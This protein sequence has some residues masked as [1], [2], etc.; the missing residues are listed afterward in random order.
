MGSWKVRGITFRS[1]R[2]KDVFARLQVAKPQPS[3]EKVRMRVLIAMV[4][5]AAVI[6]A[7]G[8]G[9][10]DRDV[11][12]PPEESGSLLMQ[13]A[14]LAALRAMKVQEIASGTTV[15]VAHHSVSGDPGGGMFTWEA[16]LDY[17]WPPEPDDPS[18]YPGHREGDNNGTIIRPDGI[19]AGEPGRWVR[20]DFREL[21]SRI[22]RADWFGTRPDRPEFDNAPA[23]QAAHDSLPILTFNVGPAPSGRHIR[24][25]T[26]RLGA[27]IYTI[28][29]TILQSSRTTLAGEGP[30][31][32]I[33]LAMAGKFDDPQPDAEKWMVLWELPPTVT[34]NNN[35]FCRLETLG[36]LGNAPLAGDGN[37][38]VSGVK[39]Q[40]AQGSW[41]RDVTI[42][43]VA[44]RG[45]DCQ[46]SILGMC[47]FADARQGPLVDLSG[48][49]G[50]Q[51]GNLSIEH[52]NLEGKHIDPETGLPIAA[53]RI[54]HMD[55]ARFGQLQF[56][57]SPVNCSI[58]HGR[59]LVFETVLV[60]RAVGQTSHTFYIQGDSYANRFLQPFYYLG[61]PPDDHKIRDNSLIAIRDRTTGEIYEK[62][63]GK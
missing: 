6:L 5:A 11:G 29:E 10:R 4:V 60:N 50:Y 7:A 19:S 8:L 27:G 48:G 46:V 17:T 28:G 39:I 13:A 44:K 14:D 1:R 61:G 40:G 53:L 26:V 25:G 9:G 58:V 54:R 23:I 24:P 47:W 20:R 15:L 35:F 34:L 59:H 12:G 31:S 62:V 42:R 30:E 32:T 43:E 63:V 57:G 16:G 37:R 56:E 2:G 33:L 55:V 52:V 41:M 21:G 51:F 22:V 38:S 45:T 49:P 3:G 18:I 36:V